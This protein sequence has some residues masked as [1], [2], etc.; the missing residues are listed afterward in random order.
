M[1]LDRENI[2]LANLADDAACRDVV[3]NTVSGM[4]VGLNARLRLAAM[5]ARQARFLEAFTT[6]NEAVRLYP[7]SDQAWAHLGSG[8]LNI[9]VPGRSQS[10]AL[11]L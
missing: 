10:E 3:V 6:L 2:R 9:L 8:A 4:Q 11:A 5:L 1:E 7:E